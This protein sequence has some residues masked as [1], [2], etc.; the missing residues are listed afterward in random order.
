[1]LKHPRRLVHLLSPHLILIVLLILA[2][3]CSDDSGRVAAVAHHALESQSKQ[4]EEL[5]RLSRDVVA[6]SQQLIEHDAEVR[7]EILSAQH[8]LQSQQTELSRQRDDLEHERRRVAAH[9]R[10]ESLLAPILLTLGTM[11]LCLLPI[12]VAGYALYLSRSTVP[13]MAEVGQILLDEIVADSPRL[14]PPLRPSSTPRLESPTD[15]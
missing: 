2:I 12:G 11:F 4:N 9:R 5:A 13:E 1:M 6:S 8:D 7:S 14:L 10:T 3:G 15:G